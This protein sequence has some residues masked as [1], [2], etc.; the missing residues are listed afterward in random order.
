M[1]DA[2]FRSALRRYW[3]EIARGEP[4]TPDD[5]DPEVA[6]LIRRLHA[7]P[8]VP[9]PDP[10][11]ARRLRESLMHAT[12]I[13]LPLTDPRTSSV[14][15]GWSTPPGRRPIL[16][17]RPVSPARW[18]P[19]HLMTALLVMLVLIGSVLAFGPGR[20]GPQDDAP[21]FLPAIIRTPATPAGPAASIETLVTTTFPAEAMPTASSPSFVIWYATIAPG[22][23]VAI[24]PERIQCCPGPQI[25]HVLAGELTLRVEGPLHV[26]RASGGTPLPAEAV[27]SGTE[28]VLR[29]GD[30]AVYDFELPATYHNTGT[31]PLQLVAGGLFGG[32][33][34]VPPAG[35][36]IVTSKERYPAAPVPS[37][38]LTVTLQRTTLAPEA[39]FPAPPS[40]SIQVVMT[41]PELGTLGERS[42]GSAQNLG[43]EPVVVY[44][45]ALGSAAAPAETPDTT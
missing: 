7:L 23:E 5:L 44:A 26:V 16:S 38:P 1:D 41:G 28:V 15:N 3:D 10:T 13:S 24:P 43:R 22:T 2:R 21:V 42:D 31:D 32:S 25:E 4:A 29:A 34:P 35:Y 30:T 9:P 17:A 20:P 6:A 18:A 27:S 14:R 45:L 11:Y 19:A 12:M 40:G 39:V 36:A 37:G 33:P 8:D